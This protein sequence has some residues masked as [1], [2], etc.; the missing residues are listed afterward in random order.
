MKPDN[1]KYVIISPD[2]LPLTHDPFESKKAALDYIPKYREGLE[3]Q[4]YYA[5]VGRRIPLDELAG[6]LTVLPESAAM[7]VM[8]KVFEKNFTQHE[9]GLDQLMEHA[10]NYV[11]NAMSMFGDVPPTL[12]MAGR[13]GVSGFRRDDLSDD[14]KKREF[15]TTGRMMCIAQM[16]DAAV[17]CSGGWMR[18]PEK[19]EVAEAAISPAD[20]P[21]RQEVAILVGETREGRLQSVL[22]I[23]RSD[24]N[25]FLG[26]GEAWDIGEVKVTGEFGH[27][28]SPEVPNKYMRIG[29]EAYLA[30]KELTRAENIREQEKGLGRII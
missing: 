6:H 20:S 1:E 22:P 10:K 30:S 25:E 7:E 21:E 29:A 3:H 19:G 11:R 8:G 26:F 14:A 18:T 17:F 15:L 5:A 2:G 28:L 16:A 23:Q 24:D 9:G 27:F 12:F 4:G 13:I